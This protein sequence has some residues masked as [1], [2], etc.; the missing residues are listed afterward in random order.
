MDSLGDSPSNLPQSEVAQISVVVVRLRR[1]ERKT[2]DEAPLS[3]ANPWSCLLALLFGELEVWTG[4]VKLGS[5]TK[6]WEQAVGRSRD[7]KWSLFLQDATSHM[8]ARRHQALP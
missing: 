5:S 2:L 3:C 1:H 7:C 6:S 4:R 8:N